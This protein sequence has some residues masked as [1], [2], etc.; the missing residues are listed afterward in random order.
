MKFTARVWKEGTWHIAQCMEMDI[1]SQGKT[2]QSA[3]RN[4][5]EA[6]KLHLEEPKATALPKSHTLDIP[7]HAAA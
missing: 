6:L 1:A 7:F 4:L 3:L 2:E 5:K